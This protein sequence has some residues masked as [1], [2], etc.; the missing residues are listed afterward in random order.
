MVYP[1]LPAET[2]DT[3]LPGGDLRQGGGRSSG[4]PD[5]RHLTLQ[6]ALVGGSMR[7][8]FRH[9]GQRA[10]LV[11]IGLEETFFGKSVQRLA[12]GGVVVRR[13]QHDVNVDALVAV[14]LIG[15][16]DDD[17]DHRLVERVVVVVGAD[18]QEG[19]YK[20]ELLD[21]SDYWYIQPEEVEE[22]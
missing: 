4:K 21:G 9:V 16:A 3:R 19:E 12:N 7:L 15:L 14:A 10:D 22:I 1:V 8:V 5:D 13:A 17:E 6:G 11:E 18:V 20:V 2:G